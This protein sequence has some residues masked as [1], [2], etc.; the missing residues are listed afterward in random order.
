MS[1]TS[2]MPLA[3]KALLLLKNDLRRQQSELTHAI[4]RTYEEIRALDDPA[5]GDVIDASCGNSSKEAVFTT[6]TDHRRQLRRVEA[7][8]ARI[9]TGEFGV[10]VSCGGTIGLKRLQALPS[11][12][13]CI[14]CQERS[15]QGRW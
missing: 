10:C 13:N 14:E 11:A 4:D 2:E 6:Y 7:A 15:E 12:N 5:P 8:L 9:A 3:S 1:L